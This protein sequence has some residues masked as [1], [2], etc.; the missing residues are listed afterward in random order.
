MELSYFCNKINLPDE[1]ETEKILG[2]LYDCWCALESYAKTFDS[3]R[4]EWRF[5]TK[6]AGW[7]KRL[8]LGK[9]E[10][11]LV[12]LYPNLEYFTAV[13]VFS[14][15]EVL[16]IYNMELPEEVI[17]NILSAKEYQEGRSFSYIV[18]SQQDFLVLKQLLEVKIKY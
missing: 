3:V 12:F 1:K 13:I 8:L 16:R 6:K 4:T 7:C 11:N 15:R 14:Q 10:R 9:E 5:Y 17:D 2:S 18:R